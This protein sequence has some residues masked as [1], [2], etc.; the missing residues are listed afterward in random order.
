MLALLSLLPPVLAG[1][2]LARAAVPAPRGPAAALIRACLGLVG[3]LGLSSLALFAWFVLVGPPGP[4]YFAAESAVFL[5]AG[6]L[7][8]F[9]PCRPPAE[10]PSPEGPGAPN[11]RAVLVAVLA[12]SALAGL[13]QFFLL[14][15]FY[16]YGLGDAW[17]TWNMRARFL[18]R[19]GEHWR[20]AFDPVLGENV[21]DYPLLLPLTVARLW[22]A[23]GDDPAW[24]PQLVA[25]LFTAA[26]V[27]LLSAA[28]TVFR[29][30][31]QGI[32]AALFLLGTFFFVDLGRSQV[33]DVPLGFFVLATTVI[34]AARDTFARDDWRPAALAG[35]AAGC[36]AWTKNEGLLFAAAVVASRAAVVTWCD[37]PRAAARELAALALGL[38]PAAAALV[39]LKTQLAGAS[40]L[41]AGQ[42][43]TG[44]AQRLADPERYRTVFSA[45]V[46]QFVITEDLVPRFGL[47]VVWLLL[48]YKQLLEG[49]RR[50]SLSAL[51]LGAVALMQL[52][53]YVTARSALSA[54]LVGVFAG[55]AW[56]LLAYG[57][58]RNS[59]SRG[60]GRGAVASS[61][62]SLLLVFLGYL[63]V[64][65]ITPLDLAQHL[66]SSFGRIVYHLWPAAL[67][68]FF[69]TTATPEEAL[70]RDSPGPAPPP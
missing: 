66:V 11:L 67:F 51:A 24:V 61:A 60:C 38:L 53:V 42:G 43:E 9:V 7:L 45:V 12:V 31:T 37:G 20:D 54:L 40:Y 35:L 13:A 14:T 46:I 70:G 56:L 64:Y 36:A 49:S 27:V 15:Y 52:G 47:G 50:V 25:L 8:F 69:L 55:L 23:A 34:L 1:Y 2:L 16:P 17:F 68:V 3:G 48:V 5:T 63:G 28:V 26:S 62:A 4:V 59:A 18:F 58:L 33:A 44:W 39:Y 21:P 10:A 6:V 57:L 29:G 41:V 30:P 32:V 65:L 19:G 22:L